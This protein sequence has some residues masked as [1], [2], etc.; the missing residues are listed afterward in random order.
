M[1]SNFLEAANDFKNREKKHFVTI[2]NKTVEVTLEQKLEVMKH[3]EHRFCWQGDNFVLIPKPVAFAGVKYA[4]WQDVEENGYSFVDD[5]MY[6]PA[7]RGQQGK[8]FRYE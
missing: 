2:Q 6:W 1:S 3:G 4:Q 8:D 5:H 7:E